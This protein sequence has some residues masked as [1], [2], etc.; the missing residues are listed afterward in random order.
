MPA[1]SALERALS[2]S[3]YLQRLLAV[4][5]EIRAD[6]QAH[7]EHPFTRTEMQAALLQCRDEDA[8]HRGM[9]HLRQQVL[10]RMICREL[11]G[12]SDL[13]EV[14]QTCTSLAE[15]TIRACMRLLE[16]PDERYGQPIGESTGEVQRLLVVGMGKLGGGELNVSSDIDLVF[17]YPEDGETNGPRRI[18]NH[19]YFARLGKR[20]IAL[21]NDVTADGF[22]FRVDMR[23]RPFGDSGPLVS[24]FDALENYLLTQG[25]E[26]ERYAWIKGRVVNEVSDAVEQDLMKL[27]TPFIY[28]KY[29]DY[30]AYASMRDLHAQIQ[31]EVRRRDMADNI[32]L[33][34]G[35]IREIEFIAQVFQLIRGGRRPLLRVRPTRDVL[36]LLAAMGQLEQAAVDLL[37][38]AYEFLRDLEHRLQYLDDA[39]TQMLPEQEED[40]RRIASSMGFDDWASFRKT[41]ERYRQHVMNQFELVFAL[42]QAEGEAVHPLSGVWLGIADGQSSQA[43]L[44]TLG[45]RQPEEIERRLSAIAQSSRYKSLADKSRRR[46]DALIPPL[47]EVASRESNPDETLSRILNFL[48]T[49]SRRESYLA[50][51]AEHPQTLSRLC[52]LHSASPWVAAY[53]NQHPILLDELLDARLLYAPPTWPKLSELLRADLEAHAG[54]QEVE[55]DVLRHF[56]HQQV[57][58]LVAQDLA[59]EWSLTTLSDHLSDLADLILQQTIQRCWTEMPGKHRDSPAFAIIGYGKLGGKEL[60]YGSDLDLI[61]L[62]D[63]DHPDAGEKYARLARRINTWLTT[64]TAAGSL[65]EVDLRLRPNGSSGL[66]VSNIASFDHYQRH[67][68]WAWEHQALTRARFCAGDPAIGETFETVRRSVL[69]L[70]REPQT[71]KDEVLNMRA[72]MLETHPADE[73]DLKHRRGGL[74]DLE[75]IVQ[76]LVLAHSHTIPSLLE[77]SG[78]IAL[79]DIAA[80]AGLIPESLASAGQEAYRSLRAHQH[81]ERLNGGLQQHA[82]DPALDQH[83]A[84]VRTLWDHVFQPTGA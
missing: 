26:W 33:G 28:R 34:P 48:E 49:I 46:L 74:V 50:L 69:S 12:L 32:K 54:D 41:L 44:A 57:F 56:Q 23:L 9:R 71:L 70:D 30:S 29:L 19:E 61:F 59:G 62:Y 53:L 65:Y 73:T 35:G 8:L 31:R 17:I 20:L 37:V 2:H 80:D 16:V 27:V 58:R 42:P 40:Q 52:A 84:T 45:Y 5:P 60:G 18:S 24:S 21:L 6:I 63:D 22:V 47:I 66:L 39:Q 81:A 36:R 38:E 11:G 51:L 68:A 82:D 67:E 10:A 75:F 55:M 76:F 25:R 14:V 3:R 83:C 15:E 7:I 4:R 72:R 13:D 1:Y 43:R 64:T 77:N 78:N 79:L